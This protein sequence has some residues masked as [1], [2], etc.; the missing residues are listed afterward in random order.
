MKK[1]LISILQLTSSSNYVVLGINDI[2]FKIRGDT[3]CVSCQYEKAQQVYYGE[4]KYL[5]KK[6]LE[7]CMQTF[8][9]V[10]YLIVVHQLDIHGTIG[11]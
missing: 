9:E 10:A 3:I 6:S 11:I 7:Q 1:N 5:N 2:M 4:S 8:S